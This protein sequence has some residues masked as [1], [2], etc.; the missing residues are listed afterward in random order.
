MQARR[1]IGLADIPLNPGIFGSGARF[2]DAICK[3][4]GLI[5]IT[6]S[7][8]CAAK[9]TIELVAKMSWVPDSTTLTFTTCELL[10][11]PSIS[12]TGVHN[13]WH[14]AAVDLARL[15][16][17]RQASAVLVEQSRREAERAATEAARPGTEYTAAVKAFAQGDL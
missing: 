11:E 14:S 5:D 3:D 12:R 9:E 4:V 8:N 13:S 15:L 6:K 2:E 1:D 10:V 17:E 16:E 7:L